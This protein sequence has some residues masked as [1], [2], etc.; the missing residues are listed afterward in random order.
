MTLVAIKTARAERPWEIIF[1]QLQTG[2]YSMVLIG[3]GEGRLG[4]VRNVRHA[5]RG[6][7]N[8]WIVPYVEGRGVIG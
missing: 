7:R 2:T 3:L 4:L 8:W 5:S 6:K 1:L